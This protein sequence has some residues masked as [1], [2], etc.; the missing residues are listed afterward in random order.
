MAVCGTRPRARPGRRSGPLRWERAV[1]RGRDPAEVLDR[2][3]GE[4]PAGLGGAEN[5]GYVVTF[6]ATALW[7]V[8]WDALASDLA[9]VLETV[10]GAT[11]RFG[12]T[13]LSHGGVLVRVLVPSAPVLSAAV[14]ALWAT[15]CAR[16]LGLPL[17]LLRKR[18]GCRRLAPSRPDDGPRHSG[19]DRL[20]ALRAQ[21]ICD[22]AAQH[23]PTLRCG[24]G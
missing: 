5:C 18:Y 1:L 22:L 12:V 9:G 4:W 3:V 6:A 15:C 14:S 7:P 13:P 17:L 2:G 19:C 24:P 16:L 8:R 23:D 11:A 10:A 21:G 20:W